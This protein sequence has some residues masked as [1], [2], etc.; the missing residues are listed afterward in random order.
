MEKDLVFEQV[1]RIADRVRKKAESGKDD[2][3]T[4]AKKVGENLSNKKWLGTVL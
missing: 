4:L 1:T 3:L 2:T